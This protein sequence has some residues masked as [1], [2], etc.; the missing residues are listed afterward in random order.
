MMPFGGTTGGLV[1]A[2]S[3]ISTGVLNLNEG[4]RTAR[5]YLAEMGE[6]GGYNITVEGNSFVDGYEN[7]VFLDDHCTYLMIAMLQREFNAKDWAPDL[8]HIPIRTGNALTATDGAWGGLSEVNSRT[9]MLF[10]YSGVAGDLNNG[11]SGGNSIGRKYTTITGAST[12][13]LGWLLDPT[14]ST[15]IPRSA[16]RIDVIAGAGGTTCKYDL[17]EAG[18]TFGTT[19]AGTVT[20]GA[21]DTSSFVAGTRHTLSSALVAGSQYW[22]QFAP[23]AAGVF[24]I[25]GIVVANSNRGI[26]GLNMGRCGANL[27]AD[28]TNEETL[29]AMYDIPCSRTGA[30]GTNSRIRILAYGINEYINQSSLAT[31]KTNLTTRVTRGI[32]LGESMILKVQHVL[33]PAFYSAP[34]TIPYSEY[35]R[36]VREV[37]SENNCVQYDRD[38][39]FGGASAA[40]TALYNTLGFTSAKIHPS[41]K[42][43]L[44]E[45][46]M[47]AR[48][49]AT[50]LRGN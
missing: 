21:L 3:D 36:V 8:G 6:A 37:A 18:T 35:A 25:D 26:S 31:F 23:P 11:T 44:W 28:T 30:P 41:T 4:L 38:A 24:A 27:V 40:T 16:T 17:F 1:V 49:I 48:I 47:L 50:G 39:A 19:G 14:V 22:V 46:M 45:A 20:N 13:R 43:Q 29:D 33:D 12:N 2:A 42:D 32:A 34:L 9:N 5:Y 10:S 15:P 7:T